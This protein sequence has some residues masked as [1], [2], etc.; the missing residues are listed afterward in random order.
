MAAVLTSYSCAAILSTLILSGS[1]FG[2]VWWIWLSG[3]EG[4]CLQP[5]YVL[6]TCFIDI[7]GKIGL[8][9]DDYRYFYS[10]VSS[11]ADPGTHG[12]MGGGDLK[13]RLMV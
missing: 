5:N 3:S 7:V 2:V 1:A 13:V 12:D 8:V 9:V 6:M 4:E 11:V 10:V